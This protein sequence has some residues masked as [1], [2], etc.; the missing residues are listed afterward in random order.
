M[1]V[2]LGSLTAFRIAGAPVLHAFFYL[3]T[4]GVLSLLGMYLIPFLKYPANPPSLRSWTA[5]SGSWFTMAAS[6]IEVL[7]LQAIALSAAGSA[8]GALVALTRAIGLAEPERYVRLF[9]DEGPAMV[10]LLKSMRRQS[11]APGYVNRLI[12]ATTVATSTGAAQ[13]L[14]EPLSE[15][16]L[17]VLR[18]LGGDLGGPE[19]ARHLSVSLNTVRT[20]TKNIYS[21][22]GTTSRRAAVHRARELHLI[23]GS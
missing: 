15:R 5:P 11:S 2:A 6:V 19:I 18:L 23:P 16:E 10:A 20:H 1:V 14:V 3:A 4:C 9:T 7:L 21:K 22:L 13:P 12:A 8:S 17:E